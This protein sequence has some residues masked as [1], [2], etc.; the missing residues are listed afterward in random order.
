MIVHI[1]VHIIDF[2][3]PLLCINILELFFPTDAGLFRCIQIHPNKT[4]LI[5]MKMNL[6]Q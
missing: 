6:V 5:N 3:D 4:Q 1:V 2:G